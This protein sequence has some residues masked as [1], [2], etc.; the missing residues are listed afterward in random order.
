MSQPAEIPDFSRNPEDYHPDPD[1]HFVEKKN[2][3]NFPP[4]AIRKC[5]ESGDVTNWDG[6]RLRLTCRY[7]KWQFHVVVKPEDGIAV[8][9]YPENENWYK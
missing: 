3:R 7:M 1:G 5:I 4:T 6:T 9:C 8:T 2:K